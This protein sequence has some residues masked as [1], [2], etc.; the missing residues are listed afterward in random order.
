VGSRR[1]RGRAHLPGVAI[2]LDAP[3]LPVMSDAKLTVADIWA[4]GVSPDPH[5]LQHLREPTLAIPCA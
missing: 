4:T 5:P 1:R 3:T 2:G